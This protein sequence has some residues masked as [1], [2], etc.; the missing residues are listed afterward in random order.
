MVRTS[1]ELLFR[2]ES[3][4]AK[5][6]DWT[7]CGREVDARACTEGALRWRPWSYEGAAR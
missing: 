3:G 1:P 4:E 6:G 2:N 7:G 5:T